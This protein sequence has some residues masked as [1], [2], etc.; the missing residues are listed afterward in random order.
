M[1]SLAQPQKSQ[2][3]NILRKT[4]KNQK[5]LT[6]LIR[7]SGLT[8]QGEL[9]TMVMRKLGLNYS[10]ANAL[11]HA[12]ERTNGKRSE[13]AKR[14][15]EDLARIYKGSKAALRP[16]HEAVVRQVSHLGEYEMVPLKG[17]VSLRRKKQFACLTPAGAKKLDLCLNVKD[18][19]PSKR[20][21]EE[22]RG[23][24]CY[25]RVRLTGPEQVD[26]EVTAWIKFAYEDAG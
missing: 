25:Y 21:I 4:G 2:L 14:R 23:S 22:P 11:V 1:S 9:R 26:A 13:D 6:S 12:V 15:E 20:L 7:N 8:R 10:D 5:Q 3:T 17:T 18:L 16:I 19:P 24:E